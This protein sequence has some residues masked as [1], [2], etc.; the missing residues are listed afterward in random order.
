MK[1]LLKLLPFLFLSAQAGQARAQAPGNAKLAQL[2]IRSNPVCGE[3]KHT[4]ETEML[5]VKGVQSVQVDVDAKIIHVAYKPAKTDPDQ[6][7][8]AVAKIGYEADGLAPDPKA[9]KALPACC[10]AEEHDDHPEAA[11]VAPAHQE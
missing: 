5:Y 10:Q 3:C 7:R 4:I 2:D 9:R 8:R 6:L 11:P 1:H